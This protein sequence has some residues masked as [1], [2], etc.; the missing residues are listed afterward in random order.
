MKQTAQNNVVKEIE[1][2]VKQNYGTPAINAEA[3]QGRRRP[4]LQA[5]EFWR[6]VA[7]G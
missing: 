7:R 5:C 3:S 6:L 1:N 2:Q 4:V